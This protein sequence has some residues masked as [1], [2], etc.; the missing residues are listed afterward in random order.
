VAI[1]MACIFGSARAFMLLHRDAGLFAARL[2]AL[3]G[4]KFRAAASGKKIAPA[5]GSKPPFYNG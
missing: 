4:S 3:D 5:G 2:V 1:F